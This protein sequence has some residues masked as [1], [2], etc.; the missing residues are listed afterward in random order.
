MLAR[1]TQLETYRRW[2]ANEGAT[3]QELVD[4]L[5]KRTPNEAML[6]G[7]AFH[8]ALETATEGEYD[9]LEADGYR[10]RFPDCTLALPTVREVRASGKYGDLSVTGKFDLLQGKRIEDHKTTAFFKPES[11]LDGYQW[12]FYLD[13]FDCDLF[14]WNVFVLKADPDELDTYIVGE[15]QIL[16]QYRYPSM[17]EDCAALANDFYE[18]MLQLGCDPAVALLKEAA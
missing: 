15:P 8:R 3:T 16:T 7:T 5:T 4:A 1:V 10:F 17:H 14:Q 2:L 6:V 12:R 9:V 13:I 11:Y 18:L